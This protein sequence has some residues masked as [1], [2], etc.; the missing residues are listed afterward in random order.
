MFK[1]TPSEII[2]THCALF[3][4]YKAKKINAPFL[5]YTYDGGTRREKEKKT[6][7]TCIHT[8][9]L[10]F[11]TIAHRIS[12]GLPIVAADPGKSA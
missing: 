5:C 7:N 10:A 12:H 2:Q 3:S 9:M 6:V 4:S 1:I 11:T 8:C